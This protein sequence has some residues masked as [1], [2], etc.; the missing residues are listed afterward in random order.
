METILKDHLVQRP[1]YN[2]NEF[3]VPEEIGQGGFGIV[4]KSEWNAG[5]LVALKR[6]KHDI[7]SKYK[8]QFI[9]E[10]SKNVLVHD[11]NFMISDFGLAKHVDD[12]SR[13]ST[14]SMYG[15]GMLQYK[16]P[17]CRKNQGS[18]LQ[19]VDLYT[20]CCDENPDKRPKGPEVLNDLKAL[21]DN[22]TSN[23]RSTSSSSM[24]IAPN[25]N[26]DNNPIGSIGISI[27]MSKSI[28]NMAM[29]HVTVEEHK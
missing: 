19:Y 14:S 22:A 13:I 15:Y 29:S 6:L 4:F 11:D 8:K 18:P 16:D 12:R 9:K 10:H 26:L 28:Y 23:S 21:Y 25:F 17:K 5:K 24:T 3:N 1:E 20:Q 27:D 2:F 7:D